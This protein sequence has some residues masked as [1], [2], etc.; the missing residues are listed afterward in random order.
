MGRAAEARRL[1]VDYQAAVPTP[2]RRSDQFGELAAGLVAEADHHP[3][4]AEAHYRNW[5]KA[6]GECG[7]C[8]L[9]E[10][11]HLADAAGRTDSALALYDRGI[12]MPALTRY[13]YDAYQLPEALKRAGELSEA[14]GDRAKAADRYR[15]FVELW[16]DADSE[17]QPGVREVRARLA[18]LATE[19]GTRAPRLLGW[20]IA[21][22]S[23]RWSPSIPPAMSATSHWPIFS[24]TTWTG[25]ACASSATVPPTA[26]RPTW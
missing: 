1:W 21:R 26:A 6:T 5:Y 4:Q 25:P 2:T 18:R 19:P 16:K 7:P 10:L 20:M 3:E 14:K 11:A 15:R 23:P 17:L 22:S 9:F 8:G 12:S 24:R 13:R